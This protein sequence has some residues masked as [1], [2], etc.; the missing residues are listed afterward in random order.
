MLLVDPAWTPDD[1]DAEPD[2]PVEALL[3]AWLLDAHGQPGLFQPNPAYRPLSADSPLDP[4]DAVLR[5]VATDGS[6]VDALGSVLTTVTLSI[7][8]DADGVAL[9]R[10]APDGVACVLVATAPGHRHH[11][12]EEIPGWTAISLRQLA[13]KLPESGIDVLFNPDSWAALRMPAHVV[14]AIAAAE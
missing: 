1:P 7:A 8:V 4:A 14:T 13:A 6:A 12:D 5:S 3:G 2:P 9:V 10:T 11:S